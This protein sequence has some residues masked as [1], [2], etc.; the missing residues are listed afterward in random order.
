MIL[1]LVV[2]GRSTRSVMVGREP[3]F[4]EN[5]DNDHCLHACCLMV[6]NFLSDDKLGFD[7][8]ENNFLVHDP[9]TPPRKNQKFDKSFFKNLAGEF[10][11]I[12]RQ[13]A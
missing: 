8:D 7:E 6:H 3:D 1:V 10:L 13:K 5:F 2:V 9:G 4:Y 12:P 11:A